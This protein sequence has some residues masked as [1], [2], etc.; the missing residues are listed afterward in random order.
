[1]KAEEIRALTTE[2]IKRKLDEAYQELFN[3]RFQWAA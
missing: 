1:M 3:L 2:E